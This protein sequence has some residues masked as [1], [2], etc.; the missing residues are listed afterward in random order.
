M[1]K[2]NRVGRYY[3]T[4]TQFQHALNALCFLKNFLVEMPSCIDPRVGRIINFSFI[5][6][7]YGC[8]KKSH[9]S[10]KTFTFSRSVCFRVF[11]RGTDVDSYFSKACLIA[12]TF[13]SCPFYFFL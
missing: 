1:N 2:A 8:D 7:L 13:R 4:D 11:V 6:S 5:D 9:K 12:K 3:V 10:L